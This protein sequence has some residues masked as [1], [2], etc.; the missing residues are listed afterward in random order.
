V[1]LGILAWLAAGT[2]DFRYGALDSGYAAHKEKEEEEIGMTDVDVGAVRRVLA[3]SGLK[4]VIGGNTMK[5]ALVTGAAGFIGSHLV[6]FLKQKG[7]WV[8]AVD[9]RSP[10][11]GTTA[12]DDFDWNCDLRDA[13]SARRAMRGVGGFDEVY[14]LAADMGGAG[15]VFTGQNDLEIMANNTRINLNTLGAACQFGIKRYLFTSSACIYPQHLQ[16]KTGAAPLKES[17][18]YPA[19]P[20]SGYG[21]EKLYAE[22]LCLAYGRATD[23]EIRIARFDPIYG[24]RCAWNNGREKAPAALCR[25]VAEAKLR[26]KNLSVAHGIIGPEMLALLEGM[27]RDPLP[28]P[29]EIWGD[30]L[31]TRSFCYIDD[32][33]E[34]VHR[35]MLSDYDS[36]LNIGADRVVSINDLAYMIAAIAQVDVELVHVPGPQGPRGRSV[37]L[38]KTI[39]ELGYAPRVSLEAGL[40]CLYRWI[41]SQLA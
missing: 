25:K 38:T 24:P 36:P 6:T 8:R 1:G 5:K 32:C 7:Y 2:G 28:S 12:A 22:R 29:V 18:A 41:E 3:T 14:A 35:L 17:D 11:F 16:I 39:K 13:H 21:W 31:A 9:Y 40:T 19:A 33:V 23:M 20:L 27:A 34:M 30:G 37:D 15:F 4:A 10:R 26:R